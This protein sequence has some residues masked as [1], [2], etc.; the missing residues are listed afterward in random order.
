MPF[1]NGPAARLLCA[2]ERVAGGDQARGRRTRSRKQLAQPRRPSGVRRQQD[3]RRIL[4]LNRR[5][6]NSAQTSQASDL[7]LYRVA[8]AVPA[9][10]F[11][12]SPRLW[13]QLL[14]LQGDTM[15]GREIVQGPR[16][17]IPDAEVVR[18][19]AAAARETGKGSLVPHSTNCYIDRLAR[20]NQQL[21]IT[22]AKTRD[23][24]WR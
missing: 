6:S 9:S 7:A 24:N 13:I 14:Q 18:N 2:D 20:G 5:K 15:S 12:A 21:K 19:D 23:H 17:Q 11:Q 10:R 22:S 3:S 4:T 8:E 16:L 1:E